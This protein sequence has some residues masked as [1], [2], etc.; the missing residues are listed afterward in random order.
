MRRIL[1][2]ASLLLIAGCK[3]VPESVAQAQ[4]FAAQIDSSH[5]DRVWDMLADDEKSV[6]GK[7]EFVKLFSDSLRVPGFD[8]TDEWSVVSS[9]GNQTQV[10]AYRRVPSWDLI[11]EI[12][13]RKTRQELLKGLQENGSIPLKKDTSRLITV[14]TT[15]QGP[16]FKVGLADMVAFSKSREKILQGLAQKVSVNLKSGIVENNFQAFFHVTGSV[17]NESDIDLKPVVFQVFIHGKL[18]GTTTVKVP[19][20]A[21]GTY[22]AEMTADYENGLT[23]QKFGTNWDHGAVPVGGLTAKVLSAAPADRKELDRLAAR[24]L[25]NKA[26]VWLF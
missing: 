7:A 14:V 16:R 24:E 9:S 15:P 13:T 19:V 20:S 1:L 2:A 23:P 6:L 17:K 8:S 5:F 22:S 12:K 11:D 25:G 26:P 3:N 4:D 18:S 10:R 21:K